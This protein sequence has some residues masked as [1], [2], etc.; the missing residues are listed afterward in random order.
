MDTTVS[1][2]S[3]L[4]ELF[5]QATEQFQAMIGVGLRIQETSLQMPLAV[6]RGWYAPLGWLQQTPSTM[7]RI[8]PTVQRRIEDACNL[9]SENVKR[10]LGMWQ[11]VWEPGVDGPLQ[12]QQARARTLADATLDAARVNMEAAVRASARAFQAWEELLIA[13]CKAPAE[14]LSREATTPSAAAAMTGTTGDGLGGQGAA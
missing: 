13:C 3:A 5:Q 12:T 9:T 4:G 10:C 7:E 1:A 11:E 6:M 14:T 2:S 8:L